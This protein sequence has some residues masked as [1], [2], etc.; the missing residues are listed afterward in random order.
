M[1]TDLEEVLSRAR[2]NVARAGDVK[3]LATE[4]DRLRRRPELTDEE[5][6]MLMSH[7]SAAEIMAAGEP[8]GP[9]TPEEA[10]QFGFPPEDVEEI[11]A[12]WTPE[13]AAADLAYRKVRLS[14]MQKLV[15]MAGVS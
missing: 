3:I 11:N 4:V 15:T 2:A 1:S 14:L 12:A 10:A 13:Q 9:I 8:L 6:H 5:R 7:L